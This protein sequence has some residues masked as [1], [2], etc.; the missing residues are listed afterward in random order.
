MIDT[1]LARQLAALSLR[2]RKHH[3][4]MAHKSLHFSADFLQ[5][6]TGNQ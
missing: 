5:Q 1:F 3:G 6:L 4:N 2:W